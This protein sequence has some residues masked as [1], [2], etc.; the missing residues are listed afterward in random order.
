MSILVS[1]LT[2]VAKAEKLCGSLSSAHSHCQG[3]SDKAAPC[4]MWLSKGRCSK[5]AYPFPPGSFVHPSLYNTGV[6]RGLFA[7]G[8]LVGILVN[9]PGK[10]GAEYSKKTS[11]SLHFFFLV[12]AFFFH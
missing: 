12:C 11:S 4:L 2:K 5:Q 1:S 9:S 10:F 7:A 8:V 6:L 3:S